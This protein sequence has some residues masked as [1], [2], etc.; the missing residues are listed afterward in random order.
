[1]G[2]KMKNLENDD[3]HRVIVRSGFFWFSYPVR[4]YG[5]WILLSPRCTV[6]YNCMNSSFIVI[7]W[8]LILIIFIHYN[9]R[10]DK[11]N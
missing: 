5:V 10:R 8:T 3:Q 7:D 11:S 4:K 9:G 2:W 6:K 1:M